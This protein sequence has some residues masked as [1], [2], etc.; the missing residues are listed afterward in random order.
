MTL[1]SDKPV[2]FMGG[3]W[4]SAG[5]S[6]KGFGAGFTGGLEA[7][8]SLRNGNTVGYYYWGPI[9]FQFG[10]Q[11][12]ANTWN[13]GVAAGPKAGLV[14]G[15]SQGSDYEGP[16]NTLSASLGT[17]IAKLI[18]TKTKD[19]ILWVMKAAVVVA[20]AFKNLGAALLGNPN[21][22]GQVKFFQLVAMGLNAV[23]DFVTSKTLAGVLGWLGNRTSL[24]VFVDNAFK[25]YGFSFD[26]NLVPSSSTGKF[27]MLSTQFSHTYYG[28]L[29]KNQANVQF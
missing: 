7:L 19:L 26:L 28:M 27:S 1:L 14:W 29:N 11:N 3:G 13:G 17:P 15:I 16:F 5:A 20:P 21:A 25:G 18:M 24:S 12:G 10:T 9:L 2:A 4:A 22:A 23:G 6:Y 8:I